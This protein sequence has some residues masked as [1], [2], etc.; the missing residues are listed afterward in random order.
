TQREFAEQYQRTVDRYRD[1]LKGSLTPEMLK[2]LNIKGTLLEQLIQKKLVLQEAQRLGLTASDEELAGIIER[3]PDFQVAGRFN[4]ERYLQLLRANRLA[5]ESF[6]EEQRDQLTM[7]RLYG[8][9]L[10][11]VRVNDAELRDRYRSE[12]EKINVNFIKV[13]ANDFIAAV[14]VNE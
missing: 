9:L 7:Q 12:R 1:M 10:D 2:S 6:E 4:K 14:K 8:M 5:P 11:S 3:V 13:P